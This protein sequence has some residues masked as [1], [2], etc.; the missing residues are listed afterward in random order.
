MGE[1][2]KPRRSCFLHDGDLHGEIWTP[3]RW[4]AV[5]SRRWMVVE[6]NTTLHVVIREYLLVTGLGST[7]QQYNHRVPQEGMNVAEV[8]GASDI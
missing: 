6:G 8:E 1:W 7:I 5:V 3:M 2:N 4:I